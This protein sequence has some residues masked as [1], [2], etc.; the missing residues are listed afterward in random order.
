MKYYLVNIVLAFLVL[1]QVTVASEVNSAQCED[2]EIE[3]LLVDYSYCIDRNSIKK[4]NIIGGDNTTLHVE[5]NNHEYS[6]SKL[7]VSLALLDVP[8]KLNMPLPTFFKHLI[9]R[10]CKDIQFSK[11]RPAFEISNTSIISKYK[12]N[13]FRAVS[14]INES[15]ITNSIYIYDDS[16]KFLYLVKGDFN[17]IFADKF[18]SKLNLRH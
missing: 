12:K 3:I 17:K 16:D 15:I 1:S 7:P 6:F 13:K 8:R 2:N 4:L 11:I 5:V 9:D 14:I 10:D 18:I